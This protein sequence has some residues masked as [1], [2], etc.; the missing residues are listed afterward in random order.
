MGGGKEGCFDGFGL[1]LG[2]GDASLVAATLT[3]GKGLGVVHGR[4]SQEDADV[5]GLAVEFAL[6]RLATGANSSDF[7]VSC[8]WKAMMCFCEGKHCLFMFLCCYIYV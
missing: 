7:A 6:G 3:F 5:E 2:L 8:K 4:G 1:L